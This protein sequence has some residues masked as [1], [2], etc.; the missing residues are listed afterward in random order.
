MRYQ[1]SIRED[2]IAKTYALINEFDNFSKKN[3]VEFSV[4]ILYA[5]DS[6][7]GGLVEAWSQSRKP[8]NLLNLFCQPLYDD[9]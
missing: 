1:F 4:V 2:V 7:Q 9:Q 3:G 5:R 6:V 8:G